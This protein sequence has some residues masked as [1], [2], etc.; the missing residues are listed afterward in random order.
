MNTNSKDKKLLDEMKDVLSRTGYAYA[1]EK[2]YCDWVG[3]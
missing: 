1:T 2:A 3:R